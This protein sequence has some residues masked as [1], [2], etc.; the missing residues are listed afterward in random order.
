MD[1]RPQQDGARV[2][3]PVA[4]A[5][6]DSVTAAIIRRVASLLHVNVELTSASSGEPIP[7]AAADADA[8]LDPAAA[9]GAPPTAPRG[10]SRLPRLSKADHV[11]VP[12]ENRMMPDCPQQ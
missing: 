9:A 10:P 12:A 7:A 1:P 4:G 2:K 5:V 3:V 8:D 6:E 11:T